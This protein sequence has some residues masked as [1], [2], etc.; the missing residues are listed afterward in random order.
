[1]KAE[2]QR[3]SSSRTCG[4]SQAPTISLPC[5]F[6]HKVQT[7][8]ENPT[9]PAQL[10]GPPFRLPYQTTGRR[11]LPK[12]KSGGYHLGM[13]GEKHKCSIPRASRV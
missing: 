5:E 1:M 10:M 6:L 3:S 12:R 13:R 9:G 11:V 4:G 2:L 7:P 8:G